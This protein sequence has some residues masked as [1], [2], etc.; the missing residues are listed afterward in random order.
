MHYLPASLSLPILVQKFS[1]CK[2]EQADRRMDTTKLFS[3]PCYAVWSLKSLI[4]IDSCVA[5]SN[6]LLSNQSNLRLKT[7]FENQWTVEE[8]NFSHGADFIVWWYS[9]LFG[10]IRSTLQNLPKQAQTWLPQVRTCC[11]HVQLLFSCLRNYWVHYPSDKHWILQGIPLGQGFMAINTG[12]NQ[13]SAWT[14]PVLVIKSGEFFA[15]C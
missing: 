3:L 4:P 2:P 5:G 7:C 12:F 14:K 15:K 9:V 1:P 11:I 8:M 6:L 13:L 10:W